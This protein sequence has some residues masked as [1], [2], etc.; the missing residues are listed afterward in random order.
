LIIVLLLK[1]VKKYTKVIR[2]NGVWG[3]IAN[4]DFVTSKGNAFKKGDILKAAGWQAPALNSARGN[5][6]DDNYSVAWTGPHYLI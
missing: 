5:I 3:F 1:K 4:D 2:E 6:F